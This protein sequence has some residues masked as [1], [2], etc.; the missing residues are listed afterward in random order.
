ME[1]HGAGLIWRDIKIWGIL[2]YNYGAN[3]T[4]TFS[5]ITSSIFSPPNY[6]F[7]VFLSSFIF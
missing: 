3:A 6:F 5:K 7:D 4:N 2:I 1:G